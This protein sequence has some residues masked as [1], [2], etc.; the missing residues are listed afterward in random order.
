MGREN[1]NG[2]IHRA[3]TEPKR[4]RCVDKNHETNIGESGNVPSSEAQS[5][6]RKSQLRQLVGFF[7]VRPKNF[8]KVSFDLTSGAEVCTSHILR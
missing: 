7:F 6:R 8:T 5:S 2:Q 1:S 3:E 4:K